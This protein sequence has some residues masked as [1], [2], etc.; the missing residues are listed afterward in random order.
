[1]AAWHLPLFLV[2][3]STWTAA[4]VTRALSI[5]VDHE[6]LWRAVSQPECEKML[7]EALGE[8]AATFGKDARWGDDEGHNVSLGHDD[9]DRHVA[10]LLLQIDVRSPNIAFVVSVIDM[11]A[12]HG[13]LFLTGGGAPVDPTLEAVAVIVRAFATKHVPGS[14]GFLNA[15]PRKS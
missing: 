3:R 7:R 12:K 5:A 6:E 10:T 11:A 8:P 2:P 4:A 14:I 9:D 13:L 15:L 1:M